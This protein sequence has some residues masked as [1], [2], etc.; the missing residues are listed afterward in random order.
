MKNTIGNE[1]LTRR[2]LFGDPRNIRNHSRN[3][4]IEQL[5]Y[6]NGGGREFRNRLEAMPDDELRKQWQFLLGDLLEDKG[7]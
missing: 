5:M 7:I 4:L 1:K 6:A 3:I 2:E